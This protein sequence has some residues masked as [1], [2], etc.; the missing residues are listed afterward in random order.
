MKRKPIII[1]L[2]FVFII[3]FILLFFLNKEKMMEKMGVPL[4]HTASAAV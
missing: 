3:A 4:K 2:L 1:T